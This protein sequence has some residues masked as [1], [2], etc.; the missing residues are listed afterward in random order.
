MFGVVL[1][2]TGM[3][4]MLSIMASG[5]ST[6]SQIGTASLFV[7]QGWAVG[8]LVS[9]M[10]GGQ[11]AELIPYVSGLFV[12]GSILFVIGIWRFNRRYV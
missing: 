9:V 8:G 2:L 7:P 1:T 12:W 4:G 6:A 10:H 3:L 5:S 11:F